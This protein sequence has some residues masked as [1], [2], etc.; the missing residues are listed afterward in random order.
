MAN[1]EN[2]FN[3]DGNFHSRIIMSCFSIPLGCSFVSWGFSALSHSC[4]REFWQKEFL[5]W[6]YQGSNP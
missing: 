6:F 3:G 1:N 4:Q 5:I 2:W